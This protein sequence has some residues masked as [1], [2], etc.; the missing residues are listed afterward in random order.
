MELSPA[1]F[2]LLG[3]LKSLTDLFRMHAQQKDISF[4]YD[5]LSPLPDAVIADKKR[6]RQILFNLLSNAVKFTD[7]GGVTFRVG[8][9]GL[10]TEDWEQGRLP[11]ITHYPLP[12]ANIR[13]QVEDTGIGIQESKLAEIFLPF[14]QVSDRAHAFEGTGLGLAISQKLVQMMGSEIQVRSTLGQGSV[15]WFDLDLPPILGWHQP[16]PTSDRPIIGYKGRKRQVLIV[17]D[18][19][20]NRSFFREMLEFVG[21]EVIEA[22]DGQDGLNKAIEFKPD[23]ILMDCVMPVLDG[24]EA[25]RRLRQLPQLNDAIIIGLSANIVE[26]TTQGSLAAGC[27]DF[28]SKPVQTD[29]LLDAIARHLGLE[30]IYEEKPCSMGVEPNWD[31]LPLVLP[32][33]SAIAILSELIKIGDIAG[34]L[35]QAEQLEK[36]DDKLVPFAILIHQLAKGFKVKQL[37]EIIQQYLADS[38]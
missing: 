11:S 31:G 34:V 2:H 12:I 9:V 32:P 38:Q 6:L 18:H 36:M 28:L 37:R 19:Q 35:D 13:F 7:K 10:E 4:T 5:I 21:F 25:T 17:D 3:F 20:V 27:H 16:N 29:R 24:L 26:T 22:V 15:F 33:P 14:H 23:V 30:W 1:E 8:Y